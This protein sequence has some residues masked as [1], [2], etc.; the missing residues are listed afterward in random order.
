MIEM[1][2]NL[3]ESGELAGKI[4]LEEM[5]FVVHGDA[6]RWLTSDIFELE[7][8]RSN[9]AKDAIKQATQLQIQSNPSPKEVQQVHDELARLLS[10][11]DTFWPLWR[12]FAKKHGVR[13]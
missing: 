3:H 5:P 8:A 1:T 7:A 10:P 12:Y 13:E 2:L 9:E 11:L 6:N 4:T